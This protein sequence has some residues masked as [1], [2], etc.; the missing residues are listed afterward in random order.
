MKQWFCGL[1]ALG[2]FLGMAGQAKAQPTYAF[3]RFDVPDSS[4]PDNTEAGPAFAGGAQR[5][6]NGMER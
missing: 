3:T 6:S 4:F 5:R 2:L 1:M